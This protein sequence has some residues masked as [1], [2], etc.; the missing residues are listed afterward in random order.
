MSKDIQITQ[1]ALFCLKHLSNQGFPSGVF[2]CLFLQLQASVG[3]RS[4]VRGGELEEEPDLRD[5]LASDFICRDRRLEKG[6]KV[7]WKDSGTVTGERKRA[8]QS[9]VGREPFLPPSPGPRP[10]LIH[11]PLQ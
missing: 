3:C 4:G 9:I 7:G 11:T 5:G 2:L 6:N 10:L 8:H 1:Q